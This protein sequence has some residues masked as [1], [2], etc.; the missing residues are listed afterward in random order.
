MIVV[1]RRLRNA[2]TS[3]KGR[4]AL[5]VAVS[6]VP[7]I[8]SIVRDHSTRENLEFAEAIHTAELSAQ[9]AAESVEGRFEA[10]RQVLVALSQGSVLQEGDR[11]ACEAQLASFLSKYPRFLNLSLGLPDGTLFASALPFK[12]PLDISDRSHFKRVMETRDFAVGDFSISRV[13]GKPTVICAIPISSQGKIKRILFV[14]L[15]LQLLSPQAKRLPLF[16]GE[17]LTLVDAL[18]NVLVSTRGGD[19]APGGLAPDRW[20][21]PVTVE[22][23][24]HGERLYAVAPV[25]TRPPSNLRVI[26]DSGMDGLFQNAQ[27]RFYQNM[28]WLVFFLFWWRRLCVDAWGGFLSPVMWR[29]F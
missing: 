28:G 26:V 2:F 22:S 1:L 29:V 25:H 15:D 16:V 13:T 11:A 18:G 24:R 12:P 9:L 19:G 6:F 14:S 17:N 4:L 10:A 20:P 3:L 7:A 23:F 21:F 27:W 5:V 8:I